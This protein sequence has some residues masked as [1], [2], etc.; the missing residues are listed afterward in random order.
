MQT[1][2]RLA[3]LRAL[4]KKFAKAKSQMIYLD[5]FR[6]SK[7]AILKG[8]FAEKN[9]D[10]SN[11]KCDDAARSHSEYIELLQGWKE[12][13]EFSEAAYWEL[14]IARDG[15]KLYQTERADRRSELENLHG[16]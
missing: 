16:E 13:I 3:Q 5:H 4:S 15:I 2:E 8:Q 7:L 11:V 1:R 10:W 6:K 9:P 14:S 12:A